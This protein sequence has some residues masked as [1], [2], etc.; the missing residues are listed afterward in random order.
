MVRASSGSLAQHLPSRLIVQDSEAQRRTT[1][2][3][4]PQQMPD[5]Y[6]KKRWAETFGCISL[7]PFAPWAA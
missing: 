3:G 6:W 7:A 2:L 5:L 4:R 1:F